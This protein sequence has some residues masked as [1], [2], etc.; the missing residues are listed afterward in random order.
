MLDEVLRE[1]LTFD[2]VL[3][4]PAKSDVL[5]RDVNISTYLTPNIKMNVPLLSAAMDTVTEAKLAIALA[6]EGGVGIIHKNLSIEEQANEVDKVKRSIS[7]MIV[8]P[9]TMSPDQEV[10]EAL[11]I[12]ERYRISGVPITQKDGKL[13]GILTNRD[14][15][16]ETDLRRKISELMTKGNLV[17]VPVGTTLEDSKQLLHKNRIEKLLVVDDH[18]YLKGLITIKDIEKNRKYPFACKDALGRL[19]VG[20]A[21]GVSQDRDDRVDALVKA[22]VD[23]IVVDSAHG[24]SM[25]VMKAV[26][27]IKSRH[28]ALQLI[29]GNVAT[30]EGTEDLIKAGVDAVKVGMGPSAI[31]TTR[32]VAGIGVPQ[33]TAIEECHRV[34]ERY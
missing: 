11:Q 21:V 17:T 28:P 5:P 18:Y 32:V 22:G 13:V 14:L 4:I 12:M 34:A 16:F 7:G 26:E 15:R 9:I 27:A 25:G 29:A 23:V 1:G 19:V 30:A 20:A 24:H 31:C 33:L 10:H 2:D 3:L 8:D 6:Q